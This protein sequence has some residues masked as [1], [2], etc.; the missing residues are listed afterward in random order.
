MEYKDYYKILGVDRKASADEIKRAYRKLARQYHP[1]KNTAANAEDRFKEVSEAY[2]VLSEPEKRQAY[3]QLG[4]NWKSGQQ[5]RPPPGWNFNTGGARGAEAGGFS[6]FFSTLF[7][8]NDFGGFGGADGFSQSGFGGGF[9]GAQRPS[10][11]RANLTI[12]LEDSYNGANRKLSLSDGR[13]LQVKI[14][15]GIVSGKTMR[16]SGQGA[17]GNDLLLE[18]S[19]A[20]HRRYELDGKNVIVT[21]PLAPW[22]AALGG[23]I[24][25]PTLGGEVQMN[26][27]AGT[28]SGQKLRL[29]GRGLPG[30]PAGDQFVRLEIRNP[31]ADNPEQ[32][33]AFEEL[34]SAFPEFNPRS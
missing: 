22:E 2:E 12:S 33:L 3:D 5:F 13:T 18:I 29:K 7:G 34:A 9:G 27:P 1:D 25:V 16:L 17:G 4:P 24:S 6:D 11:S 31:S 20:P 10:A 21:V 30:S 14:P 15:K 26:L 23:K 8:G 32:R 19:I 28:Q